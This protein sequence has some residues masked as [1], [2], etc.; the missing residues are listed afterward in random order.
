MKTRILLSIRQKITLY[1]GI[2]VAIILGII[3]VIIIPKIT[4]KESDLV[5]D[6]VSE[7]SNHYAS[8]INTK[9]TEFKQL[10]FGLRYMM[11]EYDYSTADRNELNHILKNILENNTDILGVYTGFESNAFDGMDINFANTDGH[12][13][14]GR[15]IPY[16]NR[17]S[18][19]VALEPLVGMD[20]DDWYQ[21]PFTSKTF[22]VF[23]PF[24]YEGVLMI[25]FINPIM[26][27]GDPNQTIGITGCDVSLN[28]I[29]KVA[30]DIKIYESGYAMVVSNKGVYMSHPTDK[31]LIG[32]SSLKESGFGSEFNDSLTKAIETRKT[33]F[34]KIKDEVTGKKSLVFSSPVDIGGY[35]VLTVVPVKEMMADIHSIRNLLFAL[36]FVFILVGLVIASLLGRRISFPIRNAANIANNIA[37]GDLQVD[38]DDKYL[39]RTDEIGLLTNALDSMLNKLKDVMGKIS[40]TSDDF[41]TTSEYLSSSSQSLSEGANAQS[42]SVE[43]VSSSLDQMTTNIKQNTYNA[44]QTLKIAESSANGIKRGSEATQEAVEAMKNIADK[45]TIINDIALQTNILALNAAVEAARAGA[46]GKGFAVVAAEVR[47]LA[48]KSKL[49]ADEINAISLNGVKIAENAGLILNKIVP[50][51]NKTAELVQEIASASN[52][53]DTGTNE[54]NQAIQQMNNVT[55][56]NSVSS[57]E[58]ATS[59]AELASKSGALMEIIGFFNTDSNNE[60]DQAMLDRVFLNMPNLSDDEEENDTQMSTDL[61]ES[62]GEIE[63]ESV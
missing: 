29:D 47:K 48:E 25:S 43:Q 37:S 63:K 14:T 41:F 50:D 60:N 52:E 20:S 23:E 30:E 8:R 17:F 3:M 36:S 59:A 31:S 44:Q 35:S 39:N 15:F 34:H 9:L 28:F 2:A 21:V 33:S 19:S 49:S 40:T 42:S 26:K 10:S 38:I 16:W 32:T 46:H 55:R 45:I 62:D 5:Y 24:L 57:Q 18:G 7:M 1:V 51:I 27:K 22:K 56:Q 58:L 6:K 61:D 11:E 13:N 54:V 12:D 53:Q 4:Q